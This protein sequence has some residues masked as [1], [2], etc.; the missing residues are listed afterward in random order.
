[1]ACSLRDFNVI[2]NIH[3]VDHAAVA[4]V[5]RGVDIALA[6]AVAGTY[7]GDPGGLKVVRPNR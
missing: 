1:M 6:L 4:G 3:E 5:R 7:L 2:H